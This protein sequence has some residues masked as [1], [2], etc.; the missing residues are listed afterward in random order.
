[1][2]CYRQDGQKG[3]INMMTDAQKKYDKVN[4]IGVYMKLNKKTDADILE[5]LKTKDNVQ[6]YIKM[7]IRNDNNFF[8]EIR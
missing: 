4:T 5:I 2:L 6:G 7:L 8:N 3:G 1:M